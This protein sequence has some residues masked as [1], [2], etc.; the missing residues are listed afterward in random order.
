MKSARERAEEIEQALRAGGF[1]DRA[2]RVEAIE[3]HIREYARDQ[4]HICAE[5]VAG[6]EA[7]QVREDGPAG[8][9]GFTRVD[10]RATINLA[11][12]VVVNAPEPGKHDG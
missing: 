5:H 7:V 11:H 6:L 10:G 4:R 9:I 3:R 12:A 1:A 8:R 2:A